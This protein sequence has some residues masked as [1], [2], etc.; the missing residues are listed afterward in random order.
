MLLPESEEAAG[1]QLRDR[2][3]MLVVSAE[4]NLEDVASVVLG[5]RFGS[6][7]KIPRTEDER[8]HFLLEDAQ[9]GSAKI[10]VDAIPMESGTIA[11]T[12]TNTTSGYYIVQ[13]SDRLPSEHLSRVL[14]HEVGELIA[15]RDRSSQG[16]APVRES[17]LN[18]GAEIGDRAE[19]S[20]QDHGRV[21]ELN[22]L[23][24]RASDVEL[25]EQQRAEARS[26]LSAL[27]DRCGMRPMA[28]LA[29]ADT[30][31]AE[32][33]AARARRLASKDFLSVDAERLV[34][35]LAL[36]IEQLPPTDATALQASRNAALRA[37]RQ[38]EA[39]IGRRDVTMPLPG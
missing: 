33:K 32:S 1:A 30:Y 18:Q 10:C 14:A 8:E 25:P 4:H 2:Q 12:V 20:S 35:A 17:F 9:G 22:W 6:C 13:L 28:A 26:E 3:A 31:N 7:T 36:P 11:Y 5:E 29:E 27:L 16:L 37:Q 23:A 19:L 21:G 38:V 15:V 39:F 34:D 24:T